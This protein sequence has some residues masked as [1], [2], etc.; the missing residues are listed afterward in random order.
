MWRV[1]QLWRASEYD[2]VRSKT[3][4]QASKRRDDIVAIAH[5]ILFQNTVGT[6]FYIVPEQCSKCSRT[7]NGAACC[8]SI[9]HFWYACHAPAIILYTNSTS[10]YICVTKLL[11]ARFMHEVNN[12]GRI[13]GKRSKCS[14]RSSGVVNKGGIIVDWNRKCFRKQF[15]Q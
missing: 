9:G 6:P 13:Q 11:I 14:K 15:R 5:A 8:C 10:S 3:I 4:K 2:V 1:Y 12:G 7:V